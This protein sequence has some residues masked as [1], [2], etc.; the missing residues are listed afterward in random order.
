VG[1]DD[2]DGD[3]ALLVAGRSDAE[4]FGRFYSRRVDAVLAF[5]LRRTGDRELAA[6]REGFEAVYLNHGD[7]SARAPHK[8]VIVGAVTLS[9]AT[10]PN[11]QRPKPPAG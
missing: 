6:S 11:E 7:P 10:L 9:M 1:V 2:D 3:E 8:S 5:F 4:A